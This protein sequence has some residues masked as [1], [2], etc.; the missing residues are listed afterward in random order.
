MADNEERPP[1]SP[2]GRD[3][4]GDA[5][6]QDEATRVVPAGAGSERQEP[7]NDLNNPSTEEILD[8]RLSAHG[9]GRRGGGGGG[10]RRRSA[11]ATRDLTQG[12]ISKNLWFLA[13]PQM[14]EGTL[15]MLDRVAD[16]F[17]A[18]RFFGFHALG[19]LTVAQLYTN[20]V[21]TG[22]M[23][24]DMGMQAMIA[25]AIGANR[26][27]LANHVALQAFT[28]T[29]VFSL[30]MVVIG[31]T[32]TD[33]LLRI[34]GVSQEVIDVAG[35]Y[36]QIQ[37]IGFAGQAFRMMTGGALQAAG[38]PLTPMKATSISRLAHI[39][40]T[41]V[42]IFGWGWF[43]QYDLAG[44]ALAN[45]F[46]QSLGVA[47][48]AQALFRG[49]SRLHLS[50]RNYYIDFP[51][52][53]RLVR[54]GA[55]ASGTG[56]E[57]SIVH[58]LLARLVTP[59]GDVAL[60][61]YGITRNLEMFTAMGSMGLGRASGTLVGQNLGAGNVDRAKKTILWAIVYITAIRGSIAILLLLF[62]ALFISIFNSDPELMEVAIWWVRIQALS[63][64][65][66]GSGMVFQQS[67]NVAGDTLAPMVV[68]FISMVGVELPLAFALS[69]WTPMGQYGIPLAITVA[70][71]VR[72]AVYFPYFLGGRWSR[73][74]V[75]E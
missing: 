25:R 57:R 9:G 58:L 42:L 10:G 56:M 65:V 8:V 68:T 53:A 71:V 73:V 50:L 27:Q 15:N 1:L 62:P 13:W 46:A 59:F 55:P 6:R 66:M 36:M 38:D 64:L 4:S 52:L 33:F 31:V 69:Q 17:W 51:L 43:P 60:A 41:P 32:F 72:T 54:I 28:I 67:F 23:G 14:I 19:G 70:M 45:V 21:M 16:L 12:N 5:G 47:W 22:R 2:D 3:N 75:I 20:L 44:A 26:I 39:V 49:T 61:A 11:Y 35:V 48:N 63:G 24:L 34:M 74:K 37:F 18:G 40:L 7:S 29:G 30:L